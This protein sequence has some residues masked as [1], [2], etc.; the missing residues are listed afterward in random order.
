MDR[1]GESTHLSQLSTL[2]GVLQD[3]NSGS[4]ELAKVAL[5]R[6]HSRYA[7]AVHRFLI[8]AL[9]D[10]DAAADLEQEFAARLIRGDFRNCNPD[11]GR[12]RDYVKQALRN[13]VSDHYRKK[14]QRPSTGAQIADRAAVSDGLA[15]FE[16]AFEESWRTHLLD[17]AWKMLRE[18]DHETGNNYHAVLKARVDHPELRSAELAERIAPKIGKQLT[19][20]AFRQSVLRARERFVKFLLR[21]V[22]DSLG[23][24]SHEALEEELSDL[25]LLEFCR[26]YLSRPGRSAPGAGP[27]EQHTGRR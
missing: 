15:D 4:P 11:R 9:R 14:R 8:A 23:S 24:S 21:E 3:A 5:E 7:G 17:R 27:L 22:E 20:G 2:W 25:A 16:R 18:D 26:P 12:F 6:L 10:A 1:E 19:A 13:L